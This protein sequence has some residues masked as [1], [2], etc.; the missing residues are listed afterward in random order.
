LQDLGTLGGEISFGSAI[1]NHGQATGASTTSNNIYQ[2]FLYTGGHLHPIQGLPGISF[3]FPTAINNRGVIVGYFY[4]GNPSRAFIWN[5][6]QIRDL[7]AGDH[8]LASG[9]NDKGE[10][11]G[12]AN[13]DAPTPD[14]AFLWYRG[15]LLRLPSLH[16][17]DTLGGAINAQG[18]ISG[19]SR[20]GGFFHAFLYANGKIEDL[21][22]NGVGHMFGGGINANDQVVG[23][24]LP[25]PNSGLTYAAIYTGGN[26]VDLNSFLP[27]NSGWTLY[28]AV[29]INDS[30][31]IVGDGVHN[32][33]PAA[34]LMTPF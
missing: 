18:H 9:I 6:G 2:A 29:G 27:Q 12:T 22:P 23:S 11:V 14:F 26:A 8:S 10:V 7:N 1:N 19:S 25:N 31:Q 21:A 24:V 13:E 20:V 4:V 34:F 15:R 30:G 33:I 16:G 3:I 32:G 5:G 17:E 28:G